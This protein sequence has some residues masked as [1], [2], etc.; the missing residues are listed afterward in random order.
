M[1]A[2]IFSPSKGMRGVLSVKALVLFFSIGTAMLFGTLV[3]TT[4]M[5]RS[6]QGSAGPL[7]DI[8]KFL[9]RNESSIDPALPRA[10]NAE[11]RH[12]SWWYQGKTYALDVTLY[13]SH[14]RFYRALP[15]GIPML[16]QKAGQDRVWWQELNG[17]FVAPIEGDRIFMDLAYALR[18][19]GEKNQ[20]TDDQIIEL[21]AAFVQSIPYDQAKTD[22]R[23]RGQSGIT[24]KTTYP[25]EVLYNQIGVCQDKSYLAYRLLQELGVGVSIF[26]FPDPKDDHMAVG[27]R[28]PKLYANYD[29]EYCFFETTGP[30]NIIGIIPELMPE[31]R[32]ATS[33]IEISDAQAGQSANRYQTLGRVEILNE[34]PGKEYAG[35]LKTIKTRD[36]LEQW[37]KM[38]AEHQQDLLS[39]SVHIAKIEAVMKRDADELERL[40]QKGRYEQYNT[41]ARRYNQLADD[42]ER[43]VEQYNTL[44]KTS[45]DLVRQYNTE[46]KMFYNG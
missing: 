9:G 6:F 10:E 39:Q 28:C 2:D 33:R 16:N 14:Y 25:Y 15:T 37:R 38:I 29:T 46:S 26:L 24:E 35:I 34:L 17:L 8:A 11:Q 40:K 20:L 7:V 31:S 44:V 21:V 43:L 30:G 18:V 32:I 27:I 13:A 41:L 5:H 1:L 42:L 19:L 12:F 23:T 36:T 4:I 45:N 22:R 3:V